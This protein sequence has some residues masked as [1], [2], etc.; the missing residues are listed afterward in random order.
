[1]LFLPLAL[2]TPLLLLNTRID[3]HQTQNN[4]VR[5]AKFD[6]KCA[7]KQLFYHK[8]TFKWRLSEYLELS[9][10]LQYLHWNRVSTG[11]ELLIGVDDMG[12]LF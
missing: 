9:T 12:S 2:Y 10:L 11:L 1:M 3:R 8:L 7:K 6:R 5:F 4:N